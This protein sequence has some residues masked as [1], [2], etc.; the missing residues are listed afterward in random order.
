[1]HIRLMTIGQIA[2][3]S[4][5]TPRAIRHYER[6]RL[7]Q[8]PL[9][10]DSNYRLFDS[11][12]AKRVRFISKCRSLGFSL[13]EIANLFR[14]IDDPDHT[15]AEVFELTQRHLDLIDAEMQTLADMRRTL[16]KYLSP[17]SAKKVQDCP[18]E[19]YLKRPD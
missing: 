4:K 1:M 8:A 17:C 16:A 19:D 6:L 15:C 9:R 12:A 7:I 3:K 11:D 14:I 18:M 2:Q 13:A 10:S 5:V